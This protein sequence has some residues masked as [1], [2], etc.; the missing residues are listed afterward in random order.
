MFLNLGCV[1]SQCQAGHGTIVGS[2]DS[3][4]LADKERSCIR[5]LTLSG[6]QKI[7]AGVPGST[8]YNDG[9]GS[10]ALFSG[11]SYLVVSPDSLSVMV[12]DYNNNLIRKVD[13]ASGATLTYAGIIY[14]PTSIAGANMDGPGTSATFYQMRGIS[15]S[16]KSNSFYVSVPFPVMRVVTFPVPEVSTR[17]G[18]ATDM[19]HVVDGVLEIDG[20][21]SGSSTF[22]PSPDETFF[23]LSDSTN[24]NIRSLNVAS[25]RITTIA[26]SPGINRVSGCNDGVGT[27]ARFTFPAKVLFSISGQEVYIAD[28]WTYGIRKIDLL[29][30]EVSTIIGT[31]PI[32]LPTA[33]DGVG[34]SIYIV[35]MVMSSDG[36]YIYATQ[37][38]HSGVRR[39]E[40]SSR[41]V[42]TI[43]AS[44]TLPVSS[45]NNGYYIAL[46]PASSGCEA[47]TPGKYS[48]DGQVC[49]QC[50]SGSYCPSTES[51]PIPCPSGSFCVAGSSS[52]TRCPFSMI[53]EGRSVSSANCSCPTQLGYRLVTSNVST[54]IMSRNHG[55]FKFDYDDGSDSRR[56]A[57]AII[58][59]NDQTEG[60]ADGTG[61]AALFNRPE[62][63]VLLPG[64]TDAIVVDEY[65]FVLR[66]VNLSS[67][68][69]TKYAGLVKTLSDMSTGSVANSVDGAGSVATFFYPYLLSLVIKTQTIY[70]VQYDSSRIRMFRRINLTDIT[71]SSIFKSIATGS[72]DGVLNM[73]GGPHT[74]SINIESFIKFS[75]D[76]EFFLVADYYSSIIR[77][78]NFSTSVISTIGGGPRVIGGVT[79]SRGCT[80]G[81][82]TDALFDYPDKVLINKGGSV[83]F[84][85]EWNNKAIRKIDLLTLTVSHLVGT[86]PAAASPGSSSGHRVSLK[87]NAMVFSSDESYILAAT[88][89][90][91]TKILLVNGFVSFI[92]GPASSFSMDN[93]RSMAL[94][95]P[96]E[97]RCIFCPPGYYCV[98]ASSPPEACPSGI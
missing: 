54:V 18:V 10:S 50:P 31:R 48:L 44:S 68:A 32:T 87:V 83:A 96:V 80:D 81:V 42:V 59:G 66:K 15:V 14:S 23:I 19:K 79:V 77:R 52:A 29:T 36:A 89:T 76:G 71:V 34:V 39:I 30:N 78:Y 41:N 75:E 74:A 26:G 64:N 25:R 12:L 35:D 4:I 88:T 70:V 27:N 61:T 7:I 37:T 53:S 58:A 65:N 20:Y 82:G 9:P 55:L 63:I 5:V 85:A 57:V 28:I 91:M 51:P 67:G 95:P 45:D 84:I 24:R 21:M 17:F 1:H 2:S 46:K 49:L 38:T 98:S 62:S 94:I 73:T 13:L 8:G 92:T 60:Y 47:C 90:G 56:G 72:R 86:C 11:L 22:F 97:P 43:G 33:S 69:V 93:I 40:L 3:F 6:D 16:K